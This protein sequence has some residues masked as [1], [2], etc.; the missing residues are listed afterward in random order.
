M[1]VIIKTINDAFQENLEAVVL[2]IIVTAMFYFLNIVFGTILGTS[3]IGFDFKKFM[4]GVLKGLVA[5]LGIFAF[6]YSL[7][8]FAL[9]LA[10][11]NINISV[12]VITVLEVIGVMVVW[13]IDL[14]K[15]IYEKLK[16]LKE[17]KYIKYEDI[18]V[19]PNYTN[20]EGI[21]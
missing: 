10:L 21:G 16:A 15:E 5:S 8:L 6:C 4:F 1:Q 9:T 13:D 14:A 7:N 2:L 11:I 18:Q 19:N 17:L 12:E 20:Q 3:D